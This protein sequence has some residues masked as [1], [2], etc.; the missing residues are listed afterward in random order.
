M[1]LLDYRLINRTKKKKKKTES[2]ERIKVKSMD[3]LLYVVLMAK[4]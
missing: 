2:H 4:L 1:D 3:L